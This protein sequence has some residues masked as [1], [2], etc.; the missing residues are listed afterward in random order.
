MKGKGALLTLADTGDPLVDAFRQHLDAKNLHI[1]N[2]TKTTSD[3]FNFFEF[4]H[5]GVGYLASTTLFP[6]GDGQ[7]W[8]VGAVAPQSDFMTAAWRT[9]W[10]ALIAAAVALALALLL[11][12]MLARRISGPVQ[13]LIAF[14]RRWARAIW[15]PV[16]IST[17]VANSATCRSN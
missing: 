6:I 15:T 13:A 16:P 8:V 12:A 7:S 4:S 11:A 17:A 1:S 10:Y 3:D 9:R 2:A 5:D 14:M